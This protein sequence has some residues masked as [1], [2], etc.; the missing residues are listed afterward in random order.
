MEPYY[1]GGELD[2]TTADQKLKSFTVGDYVTVDQKL[3]LPDTESPYD[4]THNTSYGMY[5]RIG[6]IWRAFSNIA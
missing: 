4:L 1:F 5:W 3:L 2:H 6:L